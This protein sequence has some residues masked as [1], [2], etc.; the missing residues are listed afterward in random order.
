MWKSAMVEFELSVADVLQLR[1]AISPM[2]ETVRLARALA[3][4]ERAG[5][6][7]KAWLQRHRDEVRRL[8][9]H[10][11]LQALLLMF[12]VDDGE[13]TGSLPIFVTPSSLT[14]VPEIEDEF[15][16]L[17][18][19]S[20]ASALIAEQLE[21]VWSALLAPSW[22]Q[23]RDILERDI[24]HRSRIFARAGLAGVFAE[25]EPSVMLR[26]Q[27]VL[28]TAVT[29]MR[30][31]LCGSGLRLMPSAFGE[32]TTLASANG[33]APTLVYPARGLG[34]CCGTRT[35]QTTSSRS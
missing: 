14:P 28:V 1:L 3:N 30:R 33:Q 8:R 25:L 20:D 21:A 5:W 34:R 7:S 18:A 12:R 29:D 19:T 9:R 24:L 22:P 15:A 2:S 16:Q 35:L 10:Y 17:R 31:T 27:R 26:D 13:P 4:P 23:L 11:D 6:S 32:Q